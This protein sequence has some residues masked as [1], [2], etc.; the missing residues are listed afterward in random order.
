MFLFVSLYTNRIKHYSISRSIFSKESSSL[1]YL[2][3]FYAC[4]H[5]QRRFHYR[6]VLPRTLKGLR[7]FQNRT[8][9]LCEN[10]PWKLISFKIQSTF[11][12]ENIPE[13]RTCEIDI[14]ATPW[15]WFEIERNRC[16]TKRQWSPPLSPVT[17]TPL[18]NPVQ[19]RFEFRGEINFVI[20]CPASNSIYPSRS[21]L[22]TTITHNLVRFSILR[23]TQFSSLLHRR[24]WNVRGVARTYRRKGWTI[25]HIRPDF[26]F[27]RYFQSVANRRAV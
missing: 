4:S 18:S 13:S 19:P 1:I 2:N 27:N 24:G 23:V 21:L 20:F 8:K 22:A 6:H 9:H 11:T 5:Y 16:K 12:I 7:W 3:I 25:G 14:R 17:V 15:A 26:A 10:F